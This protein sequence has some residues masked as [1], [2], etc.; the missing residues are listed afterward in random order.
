MLQVCGLGRT[1]NTDTQAEKMKHGEPNPTLKQLV[2]GIQQSC[3]KY[4]FAPQELE[5]KIRIG[6]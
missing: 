3:A 4:T 2:Q 6:T 5:A 1:A